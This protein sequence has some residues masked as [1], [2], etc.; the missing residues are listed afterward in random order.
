MGF[1]RRWSPHVSDRSTG[2][3]PGRFPD[4][5]W[6]VLGP[7]AGEGQCSFKTLEMKAV[8]YAQFN[9]V[10]TMRQ[11]IDD[12]LLIRLGILASLVIAFCR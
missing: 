2:V 6:I 5:P 9:P 3:S 8:I 11:L 7:E 10:K 1:M 4:I 12:R